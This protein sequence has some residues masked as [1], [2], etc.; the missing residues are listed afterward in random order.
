M[1]NFETQEINQLTAATTIGNTDLFEIDIGGVSYKMPFSVINTVI[2]NANPIGSVQEWYT[3]TPPTNFIFAQGQ[4]IA[5][6]TYSL[7]FAL[8]GTTFG[9]GDGTNTFNVI[10]KREVA[11]IGIG[12]SASAIL[13]VHDV[14]TTLG[15]V[16]M[17][18]LEDHWHPI[19]G[20]NGGPSGIYNVPSANGNSAFDIDV[21]GRAKGAITN[22]TYPIRVGAVTRNR[23][24][25]CNY[26]IKYQ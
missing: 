8:W 20:S 15:E 22:G 21:Q 14:Y 9:V 2:Q 25:G 12:T 4:A 1:N 17:D 3:D 7:L 16:K 6:S 19:Y 24:M 10:D 11:G 13:S 23:G 5:R 26:I 18:Q